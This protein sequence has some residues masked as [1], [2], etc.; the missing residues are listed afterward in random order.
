MTCG[1]DRRTV[2]A[3]RAFSTTHGFG[4]ILRQQARRIMG[5][6]AERH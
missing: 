4:S 6:A 1:G 5:A 2:R 3:C